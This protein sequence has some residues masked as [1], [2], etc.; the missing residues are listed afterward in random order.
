M[1]QG[2]NFLKSFI[3][4]RFNSIIPYT[5]EIGKGT[6][7]GYGGIGVV[8]HAKAKIGANC[9]ISQNVTIGSR[10]T[11]PTIDDYVFIGPGTKCL[12]GRIGDNVVVDANSVVTKEVPSNCVI[13]GVPTKVISTDMEKYQ[14]YIKK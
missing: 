9:V 5:A 8:I 2:A 1:I 11:L 14:S 12:G 7:L 10:E 3:H 13:A 4:F 6:R